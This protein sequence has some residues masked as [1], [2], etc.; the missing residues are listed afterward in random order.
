MKMAEASFL[1]FLIGCQSV[2]IQADLQAHNI[3]ED[4]EI[5]TPILRYFYIT[6]RYWKLKLFELEKHSFLRVNASDVDITYSVSNDNFAV[7]S[8]GV[9]S[10]NKRLDADGNNGYYEFLVTMT[11]P[12]RIYTK[13]T[14]DEEPRFSQQVYTATVD[15]NA[16]PNTLV[17][18]VLAHDK[19]N[20]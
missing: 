13:N 1:L 17:T 11:V 15:G 20:N 8:G 16:G 10:N 2:V 5:G 14:N 3:K 4:I 6:N 9:I 7:D 12:V 18:A 19:V